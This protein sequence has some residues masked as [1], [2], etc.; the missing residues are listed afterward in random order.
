MGNYVTGSLPTGLCC[1]CRQLRVAAVDRPGISIVAQQ[2]RWAADVSE[3]RLGIE[4]VVVGSVSSNGCW[5]GFGLVVAVASWVPGI[6]L[7]SRKHDGPEDWFGMASKPHR[8]DP[9]V[10]LNTKLFPTH[11]RPASSPPHSAAH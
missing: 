2:P 6:S 11:Y 9:S 7:N 3:P 5:Q 8:C 1:S 10:W 4:E